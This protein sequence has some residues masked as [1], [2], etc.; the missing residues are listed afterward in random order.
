MEEYDGWCTEHLGTN[1][2]NSTTTSVFADLKGERCPW[3]VVLE[4]L[5]DLLL[6]KVTMGRWRLG[7]N[8]TYTADNFNDGYD[9]KDDGD[10]T[11]SEVLHCQSIR[12]HQLED[13]LCRS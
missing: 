2:R 11:A 9:S 7:F 3:V 13:I 1:V 6:D 4:N 12:L 10:M 8:S 5:D